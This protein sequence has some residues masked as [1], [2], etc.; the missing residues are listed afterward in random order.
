[1][2]NDN[3][4]VTCIDDASYVDS[5]TNK[6]TYYNSNPS[7]CG[8]KD[9]TGGLSS[10]NACCVCNGHCNN[11]RYEQFEFWASVQKESEY[12]TY[13]QFKLTV[14]SQSD[15]V[16]SYAMPAIERQSNYSDTSLMIL[17]F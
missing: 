17:T 8:T 7:E 3:G 16:Q 1:M 11:T 15:V 13:L 14:L 4:G 2:C 12:K 9:I 6:C 5:S 10:N